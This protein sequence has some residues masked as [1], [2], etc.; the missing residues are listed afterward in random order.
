DDV[1]PGDAVAGGA[2]GVLQLGD[3]GRG[4]LR[5]VG[6][7]EPLGLLHRQVP[8]QLPV[9]G[10]PRVRG[11]ED[12]LAGP[13]GPG[14]LEGGGVGVQ[15]VGRA[16]AVAAEGGDDRDDVPVQ[17]GVEQPGVDPLD[18][19]GPLVVDALEDAGGV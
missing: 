13:Q 12:Q 19:A 7:Q 11:Q 16:L 15:A 4:D 18:L 1:D 14:H 17:Q 10:D 8:E 9:A 2:D 5:P 3:Q 6:F